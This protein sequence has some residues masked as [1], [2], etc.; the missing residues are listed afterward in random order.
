MERCYQFF[1]YFCFPFL[2]SGELMISF[3]IFF[4]RFDI[5][6]LQSKTHIHKDQESVRDFSKIKK[7]QDFWFDWVA[8]TG[9]GFNSSYAISRLMAQPMLDLKI[10][11]KKMS[12]PRGKFCV[13]GGDLVT[14]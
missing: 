1:L 8:D 7:K 9:D 6:M 12:L 2:Y 11:G 10:K 4:Q 14:I 5:R 13:V 3:K